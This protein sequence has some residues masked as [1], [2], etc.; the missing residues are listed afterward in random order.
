M[1]FPRRLRAL[2]DNQE[3]AR[4]TK[5]AP[6]QVSYSVAGQ[7]AGFGLDAPFDFQDRL[8]TRIGL[9]GGARRAAGDTHSEDQYQAADEQAPGHQFGSQWLPGLKPSQCV[10][11]CC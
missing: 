7:A 10:R 8:R 9:I 11:A 4:F 1:A 2:R 5:R 3:A 6:E